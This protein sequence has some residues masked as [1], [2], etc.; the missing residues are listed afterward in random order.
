MTAALLGHRTISRRGLEK[1]GRVAVTLGRAGFDDPAQPVDVLSGGWQ[2]RLAIA[3]ELVK[4]PDV[5][6]MDEPT[7]HL[8]VEGILWLEELLRSRAPAYLVVSHDRWFLENVATRMLE[9]DRRYP[10]RAVPGAGELQRLPGEARRGAAQPGRVPGLA[11][12][13]GAPRGGV[14][15][16]RRQG[17]H[18]QGQGA[19]PGGRAAHRRARRP[20]RRAPAQRPAPGSGSTSTPRTARPRSCWWPSGL[21]KS[22]DGRP[23]VSGLD[24]LLTP[25]MTARPARPQRQRQDHA[26]LI[27]RRQPAARTPAR[28]SA[29][30]G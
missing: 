3:R 26:P 5:L 20:R 21:A 28:S 29:P 7:N 30:T 2:K 9:L 10:E 23:I 8:D 14:A 16:A 15:A 13:Q 24:L 11:R 6:L 1:A 12:Q 27:A 19:H 18:H 25:G 4:A 17:A 22:F